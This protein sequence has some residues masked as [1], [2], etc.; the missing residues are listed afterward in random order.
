[1]PD[2]YRSVFHSLHRITCVIHSTGEFE[3]NFF[4]VSINGG[5]L[6]NDLDYVVSADGSDAEIDVYYFP[7][8]HGLKFRFDFTLEHSNTVSAEFLRDPRCGVLPADY[9]TPQPPAQS[10][11]TAFF[12]FVIAVLICFCVAYFYINPRM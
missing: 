3:G 12:V 9:E 8:D 4:D 7:C 2:N 6:R 10:T 1:M 5:S 11:A